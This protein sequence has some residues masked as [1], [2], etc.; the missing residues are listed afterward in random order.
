MIIEILGTGCKK[1]QHLTKITMDVIK[2]MGI[3]ADVMKV[4]NIEEISKR[5]VLLTPAL[6]LD[7][8]IKSSGR[9]PSRT[10]IKEWIN[11][12]LNI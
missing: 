8:E 2:E 4:D 10:D 12:K 11:K 7:G 9:L 5:G 1:C 6:V 3:A